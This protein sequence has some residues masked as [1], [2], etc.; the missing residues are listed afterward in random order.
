MLH[1]PIRMILAKRNAQLSKHAHMR[2]LEAQTCL[3]QTNKLIK[4]SIALI[5]LN[6]IR[7]LIS[8]HNKIETANLRKSEL[9][10]SHT[11]L[12]DLLPDFNTI[13]FARALDSTLVVFQVHEGGSQFSPVRNGGVE[14]LGSFV[15]AFLVGFVAGFFDIGD[16][17]AAE[18]FLEFGELVCAG[19]AECE[20]C[21]D[22]G[23]A[24]GFA[25]HAQEFDEVVV[26]AGAGGDFDYFVEV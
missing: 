17:G 23:L 22:G 12:V 14:D 4:V 9:L 25:G 21:I 3:K 24:E 11:S 20:G 16:I 13:G 1:N 10:L 15:V 7:K 8:M 19:V 26:F 18:E 2:S 6:Q 5:L